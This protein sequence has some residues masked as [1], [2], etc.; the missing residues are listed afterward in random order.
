MKLAYGSLPGAPR[1]GCTVVDDFAGGDFVAPGH[2]VHLW[3]EI[4]AQGM[5][6]E[7][8]TLVARFF[9]TAFGGTFVSN[10]PSIAMLNSGQEG[11]AV[12]RIFVATLGEYHP[13][14]AQDDP[15]RAKFTDAILEEL[16]L[17]HL[18][19]DF[20]KKK[21]LPNLK[22][23]EYALAGR[24]AVDPDDNH[25]CDNLGDDVQPY[26]YPSFG[27]PSGVDP[28][29]PSSIPAGS[30][31]PEKGARWRLSQGVCGAARRHPCLQA[32]DSTKRFLPP[33]AGDSL[34]LFAIAGPFSFLHPLRTARE[35][36]HSAR[37]MAS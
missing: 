27:T 35:R 8:P 17:A 23:T 33:R 20:Q 14:V 19:F 25:R 29:L 31:V 6:S 18:S 26:L 22:P 21:A 30:N 9:D 11:D 2:V 10:T 3:Q 4:R 34:F 1:T 5:L 36:P 24:Y 7:E 16:F 13:P 37:S 28:M 32:L 15:D 12:A